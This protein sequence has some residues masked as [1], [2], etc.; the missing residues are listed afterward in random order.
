[1]KKITFELE[2]I[3]YKVPNILSIGDYIKIFKI[4]NLFEEDYLQ[5]KILSIITGAPMDKLMKV[6]REKIYTL[7]SKILNL[8]PQEKPLF[9]DRFELNGVN[10]GF[11]PEWKKMSFG[12][13]ADLDTLMTKKPDEVLDNLHIITAILYRP[14]TKQKMFHK[15]EIEDYDF[16]KLTD[17]AELFKKE[18]DVEYALGSQFFFTLFA[19]IYSLRTPISLK[20]WMSLSWTQIQIAWMMRKLIWRIILKRPLDGLSFST[21]FHKMILQNMK[22]L[23]KKP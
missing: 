9:S 13:F 11:I 19:K 16:N 3:E 21:E 6:D 14:I 23:S 17:R 18:L 10:Y 5:A 12:E 15:Y 4:K 1:M 7:S 20:Q 8:I 22:K 2:G